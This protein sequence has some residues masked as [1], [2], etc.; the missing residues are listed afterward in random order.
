MPGERLLVTGARGYL[1][2]RL[3]RDL[4]GSRAVLADIT[5]DEAFR[6]A[7]HDAGPAAALVHLAG[8]NELVC[9]ADITRGF[10]VNA[11]SLTSVVRAAA[12]HG[13]RRVVVF[14]TFHV[15]GEPRD[16]STISE[17]TVPVPVHPYG[18][19]KLAGEHVA[20]V[21]ARRDGV[22][23]AIVRVSNGVGAPVSG[24]IGRW[25][26]VALDLC[27]QAHEQGVLTLKSSGVQRRD[28]VSV[29]DIVTAVDILLGADAARLADP[30]FNL[31]SGTTTSVRELAGIVA[32]EYRAAYGAAVQLRAPEP[33]GPAPTFHYDVTRLRTLGFVPRT[34]MHREI[35]ETLSFCE[36]FRR[37]SGHA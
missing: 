13:V 5:D 37:A 24:D 34:E 10:L 31:G 25:S 26:L 4:S 6:G 7:L 18:I 30:V 19:T 27:R 2:G 21:A 28:F 8:A 3:L 36:R 9:A 32:A 15:Y 23:L 17:A 16:G 20:R 33:D 22:E 35:R 1:G 14:S 29:S 11:T 12:D